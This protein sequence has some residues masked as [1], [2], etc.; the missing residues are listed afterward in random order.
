[1]IFLSHQVTNCHQDSISD[2]VGK[3]SISDGVGKGVN[4][5]RVR[6]VVGDDVSCLKNDK[7]KEVVDQENVQGLDVHCPKDDDEPVEWIEDGGGEG[8]VN[9][10][11]IALALFG[12]LWSLEFL[13]QMLLFPL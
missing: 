10:D 11:R 3:D 9:D 12:K 6:S 2:D 7:G 5:V 13:I 4:P 1:M 8:D